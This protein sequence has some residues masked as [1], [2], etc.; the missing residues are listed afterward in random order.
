MTFLT[1]TSLRLVSFLSLTLGFHYRVPFFPPTKAGDA[2]VEEEP[3]PSL[4]LISGLSSFSLVFGLILIFHA[5]PFFL[6]FN[7]NFV[8]TDFSNAISLVV[9]NDFWLLILIALC[10]FV[11]FGFR[12]NESN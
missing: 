4:S 12:R 3:S 9:I 7:L 5:S 2:C 8:L 6:E 11:D 1:P 10:Q